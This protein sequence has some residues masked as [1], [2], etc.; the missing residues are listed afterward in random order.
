MKVISFSAWGRDRH[1]YEG[2]LANVLLAKDIYPDWTCTFFVDH[3]TPV[4]LVSPL[5]DAGALVYWRTISKG[6]WEGLFWRF[7]P[8]FDPFVTHTLVRD[9][10]SRVN[11]REAAAV[12]QWLSSGKFFHSMRDHYEHNVPIMGGMFGCL[13]WPKFE[14]LLNTWSEYGNKGDDQKFLAEKIWPEV[15]SMTLAHDRY[16]DGLS[17]PNRDGNGTYEYKP[18]EQLGNHDLRRFP[19]HLPMDPLIYGEH[20]GA[21]VGMPT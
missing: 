18:L 11:P 6:A 15:R 20:V 7:E 1:F 13:S 19:D 14:S 17:M 2:A 5:C 3:D 4:S 8:I 10:D 12:E 21:R 16:A 9:C